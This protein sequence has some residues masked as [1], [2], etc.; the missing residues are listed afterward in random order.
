M[1]KADGYGLGA[2]E[3]AGALWQAGCRSFF[4]AHLDEGMALRARAAGGRRSTC[5]TACRRAED[6]VRRDAGL[7]PVLNHPGELA[8]LCRR[9]ATAR[10]SA[11]R[12]RCRSTPAC[13][14][15]A[16]PRPSFERLDRATCSTRSICAW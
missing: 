16:S 3:V 5:C 11:C 15:W 6:E 9:G 8:A 2:G 12:R 7:I 10:A 4:V 14:G 13:A 1:V